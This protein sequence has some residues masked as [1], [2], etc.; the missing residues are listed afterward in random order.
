MTDVDALS[1]KAAIAALSNVAQAWLSARPGQAGDA[2]VGAALVGG[3]NF[4]ALPSWAVDARVADEESGDVARYALTAIL[5]SDDAEAVT[6]AR[7]AV[8][9]TS[10]ATAQILDP[11]SLGILGG[12]LI[13][14]ILAAR[15]KKVGSV[16]FYEGIP[17][18]LVDVLNAGTKVLGGGGPG[19]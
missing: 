15:V 11:V 1:D 7:A 16:E 6:W 17:K 9:Q 12:V 4:A 2:L 5:D 8:D 14:A 18:E 3:S 19:E 13:G 10:V